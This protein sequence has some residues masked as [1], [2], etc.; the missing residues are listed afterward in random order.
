MNNTNFHNSELSIRSSVTDS[1]VVIRIEGDLELHNSLALR[2]EI[3]LFAGRANFR[4]IVDLA[5]LKTTDSGG[6]GMLVNAMR[7]LRRE[8]GPELILCNLS[9]GVRKTFEINRMISVFHI[10]NNPYPI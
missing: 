7:Q 6:I 4:I 2:K 10:Q 8:N 1:E 3:L 5:G 9:P